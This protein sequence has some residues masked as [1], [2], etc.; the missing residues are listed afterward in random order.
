MG[1][2]GQIIRRGRC[3]TIHVGRRQ[4]NAH[5][6]LSN[7]GGHVFG[8]PSSARRHRPTCANHMPDQDV[9]QNV[10]LSGPS[11][12]SVAGTIFV[13]CGIRATPC[14]SHPLSTMHIVCIQHCL[15]IR[16]C[17][18]TCI[19]LRIH[20]RIHICIQIHTHIHTQGRIQTSLFFRRQLCIHTISIVDGTQYDGRPLV[21]MLNI[22]A[23]IDLRS[24]HLDR[25]P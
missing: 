16:T 5:F 10:H 9:G 2:T 22:S 4:R 15:C 14:C 8:G 7:I 11:R 3:R 13:H 21:H 18:R 12:S 23:P 1:V 24:T 6:R 25:F 20:I 19:H 17:I